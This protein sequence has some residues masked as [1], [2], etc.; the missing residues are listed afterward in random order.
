VSLTEAEHLF[1]GLDEA[2]ANDLLRAYFGAL[3]HHLNYR[4]TPAVGPV[5]PNPGA[6]TTIAP[7]AFPG[8]PGGIHFAVQF[9]VP[10]IDFDPDSSGGMP[11]PLVL[12]ADE[13]SIRT[14][15]ILSVLCDVK[16]RGHGDDQGPSGSL[17]RAKLGIWAIGSAAVSG[18]VLT[19]HTRAVELVDVTPDP[20]ESVLECLMLTM[21][22]AVLSN[23]RIPIDTF[24]AGG[25]VL[26]L[27]RGPE[28]ED[29]Q[30]KLYGDVM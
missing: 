1:A 30:A 23:V 7:I 20:L 8:A 19:F 6:W 28:L 29:D 16:D 25:F 15:V 2:G 4:T 5:P 21:L 12:Q 18:G 11:P 9:D 24:T 14:T 17:L 22:Q 26:S 27:L 3:P 13:F 10:V